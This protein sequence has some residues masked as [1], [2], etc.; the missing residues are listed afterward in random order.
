M[1]VAEILALD[2]A[3]H[4]GDFV[5]VDGQLIATFFFSY[6]ATDLDANRGILIHADPP[7]IDRLLQCAPASGGSHVI[8]YDS[9]T[10]SG[11]L[12][13]CILPMFPVVIH[14]ITELRYDGRRL[15]R[16]ADKFSFDPPYGEDE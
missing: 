11:R 9:C 7:I 1:T 12:A 5:T 8:F 14:S 15:V 4:D 2:I 13:Q 6:I 3:A 16:D 10:I